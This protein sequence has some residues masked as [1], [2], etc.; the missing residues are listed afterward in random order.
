MGEGEPKI[1]PSLNDL[2]NALKSRGLEVFNVD[3]IQAIFDLDEE[4]AQNLLAGFLNQGLITKSNNTFTL[5][6][7]TKESEPDNIHN[8]LKNKF[9]NQF[10]FTR[11]FVDFTPQEYEKFRILCSQAGYPHLPQKITPKRVSEALSELIRLKALNIQKFTIEINGVSYTIY[12]LRNNPITREEAR[13]AVTQSKYYSQKNKPPNAKKPEAREEFNIQKFLCE[14]FLYILEGKHKDI[15]I[16]SE[17]SNDITLSRWKV[18]T[19]SNKI[20]LEELI[21]FLQSLPKFFQITVKTPEGSWGAKKGTY[22]KIINKSGLIK[23]LKA[24]LSK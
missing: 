6:T 13:E 21:T 10:F 2:R 23:H 15:K 12:A 24:E 5:Q 14:K 3:N 7:E 8:F 1:H 20:S 16:E 17:E 11:D 9:K 19:Y 4:A 22:V 18:A